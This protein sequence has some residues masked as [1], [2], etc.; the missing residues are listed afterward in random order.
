MRSW[1]LHVLGSL[2]AGFPIGSA[3]AAQAAAPGAPVTCSTAGGFRSVE[4]TADG[5]LTFR[6]CAPDA[7][8]VRVTSADMVGAIPSGRGAAAGLALTRDATGLWSGTTAEAVAPD[9]YRYSFSVNGVV[10]PDPV[11]TT[12]SQERAGTQST[13]EVP[14][15]A[16]KFQSY[17]PK[18]PHGAVSVIEY[19]S[20]ALGTTRRAHVYTPPGYMRSTQSYPVLYLVNGAG[21]SD[22][23]WTSTGHAQYILDNLI[24][25]GKARPMIIV[26]PAGHTPARAGAPGML[27]NT[28][29]G[30]DLHK[31]LIPHIDATFRTIRQPS[32]RAMAGLSMGGAHTIQ[33]GLTHP[34]T[35]RYIGVFSMGLGNG[36]NQEEVARYEQANAAAL[37]RSAKEMK[38]VYY[39]IGKEDFLYGTVA[40]TRA[41]LDRQKIRHVYNESG[42]GHTWIN[43]RRYLEDF[44]PRLF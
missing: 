12:F 9:N 23:N 39:A 30:D 4:P 42:G 8:T 20:A 17:D 43:W 38:L 21:D 19:W 15:A 2:L 33:F 13:V 35:F 25:A 28:D 31:V 40:P 22:N 29:F 10:V 26:M 14:G 11:A 6:L 41:M 34:E 44:L 5:R 27:G 37:S 7:G 1:K 16:A 32:S 3:W 36:G 18:I 24:A